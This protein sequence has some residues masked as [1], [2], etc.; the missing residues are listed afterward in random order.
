MDDTGH[1]TRPELRTLEG[2]R[3]I[4][5]EPGAAT[6]YYP[7]LHTAFWLEHRLWGNEPFGYHLAN[8]FQHWIAALLVV[9]LMRRLALPGAWLAGTLFALHPVCVEAVAWMSEQKSTLSAVF[10]LSGALAYMQF[11][12]VRSKRWYVLSL[13]LFLMALGSKTVTASLP[14]G[15]LLVLWWKR[16]RLEWGRDV[17]PLLPWF[18]VGAAASFVTIWVEREYI[19]ASGVDFSLSPLERCLVAGRAIWFYLAKLLWPAQL[20]FSYPRWNIDTRA[21]NQYLYPLAVLAVLAGLW[22]LSRRK[23]G[24]LAGFL[25]F[26]GTLFP[27]LGFFNV[28]P[29][30]YSFVADHYQYL[31][32]LG[33]LVPLAAGANS[34]A[35]R[36]TAGPWTR[37]LAAGLLLLPLAA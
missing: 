24:P 4:W 7:L 35:G 2:L 22:R 14:A 11:D 5:F 12:E 21:W 19:G 15:L 23:R 30:L 20:C 29:F 32:T 6:Q 16:G 26:A 13:A 25:F 17:V 3:R 28:Y 27:A 9:L 34:W 31:A 8:L 1:L 36:L 33:I 37:A 18:A 10:Y